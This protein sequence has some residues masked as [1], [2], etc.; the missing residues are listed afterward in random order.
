MFERVE[1]QLKWEKLTSKGFPGTTVRAKVHGG[2]LVNSIMN[3][4]SQALGTTFIPDP[5]HEWKI[6]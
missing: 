3:G 4:P 2:W 1:P 5:K 6:D